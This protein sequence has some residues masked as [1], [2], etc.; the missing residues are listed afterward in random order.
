MVLCWFHSC[1]Q[2]VKML[3]QFALKLKGVEAAHVDGLRAVKDQRV[4]ALRYSWRPS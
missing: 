4:R 2:A 3:Q 1:A